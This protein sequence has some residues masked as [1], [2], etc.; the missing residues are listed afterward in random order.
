MDIPVTL[1]AQ[2]QM[3]TV[4]GIRYDSITKGCDWETKSVAILNL[5]STQ[6]GQVY[7]PDAGEYEVPS[8]IYNVIGGG[9]VVSSRNELGPS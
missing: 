9:Q 3:L 7:H 4:G 2:S 8:Q 5:N 1:V 6:W